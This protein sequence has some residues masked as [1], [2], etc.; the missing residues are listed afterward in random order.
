MDRSAD[1]R[2]IKLR[3]GRVEPSMGDI[4]K[5]K[6]RGRN[7]KS[8]LIEISGENFKFT[9]VSVEIPYIQSDGIGLKMLRYDEERRNFE[10][11]PYSIDLVDGKLRGTSDKPGIF[12][13]VQ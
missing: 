1:D 10:D 11:V 6:L 9:S 4:L 5:K 7:I 12:V 8:D 2:Y 3:A 13:I